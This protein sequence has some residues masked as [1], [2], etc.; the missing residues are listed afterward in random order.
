M[1]SCVLLMGLIPRRA[2]GTGGAKVIVAD[3]DIRC[4]CTAG[5]VH[6]LVEMVDCL[7]GGGNPNVVG[8]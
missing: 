3:V 8:K 1:D 5:T 6:N 2:R 7:S 4:R